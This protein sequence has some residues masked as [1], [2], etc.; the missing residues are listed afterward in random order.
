MK[1]NVTFRIAQVAALALTATV[2]LVGCQPVDTD[3]SLSPV[4]HSAA[5]ARL[6]AD[7]DYVDGELL[8]Q[9]DEN[10]TDDVKNKALDKVKGI[11]AEKILTKAMEKAGKK[12]GLMVVKVNKNVLEA[13]ADLNSTAGVAF[14]EPNFIYTHSAVPTDP[15]FTNGS[16][17]GMY[18]PATSPANQYGSNAAAAWAADKTGSASVY[19]GIIDEGIQLTH[20]DLSGQ[21]WVNPNDPVDGVDND[22]D[23]YVDDTNGWDFDGNDRTI[24]DGGTRGSSDDHG[25]HVS[26]TIGAKADGKGVVGVN[27]KITLISAKF[28]GKR[29]GTTANAIKAVDYLTTLKNKGINI[30][31]SNNSWGGGGYSQ[32]LYDAISRANT[33]GI[34]FIA[35]AGNSGTN[36]DATASYPSNY[37]LPNVIAVAAID[38]TGALASFSQY[39]ATTVDLGAPGVAINSTTA[40]NTY[41]SYN[42]TSMATPHVTG[43]VALYAST[44]PGATVAQIRNAILSSAAPTPSLSGK[45]VT[46]GRLDANAALAR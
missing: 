4:T 18:G 19:V 38:N 39:G 5:N 29:G 2:L 37:D 14:A 15:F 43:A 9:F 27:W 20:P 13:I 35:A 6:K 17:W 25:T 10:A 12:E 26:G 16:L 40:F 28:L 32:A 11:P 3:T 30:V 21:V 7:V 23:G 45:T 44:H 22:K 1:N 34:M 33:A 24:Y 36:N 8:V 46:G 31:A 41:S 42:G